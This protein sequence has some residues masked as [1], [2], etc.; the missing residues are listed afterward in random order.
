MA[1]TTGITGGTVKMMELKVNR[2]LE[3]VLQEIGREHSA[4]L[5]CEKRL[6]CDN[7]V[8]LRPDG[9]SIYLQTRSGKR[10]LMTIECKYN[11]ASGN[12]Y[13]R[14]ADSLVSSETLC[15]REK[16]MRVVFFSGLGFT[17]T[18]PNMRKVKAYENHFYNT[19]CFAQTDIWGMDDVRSLLKPLIVSQINQHGTI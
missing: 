19:K 7:G 16:A 6:L 8:S 11:G 9:G 17:K 5:L 1:Q 15:V 18:H 12:A 10:L 2:A 14:I 4:T 3:Y 13:E